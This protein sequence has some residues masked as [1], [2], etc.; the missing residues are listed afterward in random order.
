MHGVVFLSLIVISVLL[1]TFVGSAYAVATLPIGQ[2]PKDIAINPK[3]NLVYVAN[4][5]NVPVIDGRT[6]SVVHTIP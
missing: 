4:F 6:N 3:T 2:G 5:D 1:F